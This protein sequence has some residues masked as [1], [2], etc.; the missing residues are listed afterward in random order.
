MNVLSDEETTLREKLALLTNDYELWFN[1]TEYNNI[2]ILG[3]LTISFGVY[4]TL[5]C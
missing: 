4:I 2:K 1:E 5:N 3:I